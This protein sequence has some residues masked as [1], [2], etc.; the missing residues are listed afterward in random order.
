MELQAARENKSRDP[1][2]FRRRNLFCATYFFARLILA[3]G[4]Y[5]VMV[6]KLAVFEKPLFSQGNII[7]QGFP[8]FDN[9][10]KFPSRAFGA[11]VS[12]KL[13]EK[14]CPVKTSISHH[15]PSPCNILKKTTIV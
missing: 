6:L 8:H 12:R 4:L 3:S 13:P 7:P 15:R 2:N 9:P 10:Q 14:L 1:R 5:V 11:A